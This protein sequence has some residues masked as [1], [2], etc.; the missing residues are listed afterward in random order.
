LG[1]LRVCG[2]GLLCRGRLSRLGVEHGKLRKS[3][4]GGDHSHQHQR[5]RCDVDFAERH[6]LDTSSY[7][8]LYVC[9]YHLGAKLTRKRLESG[10]TGRLNQRSGDVSASALR[11]QR[12]ASQDQRQRQSAPGQA[13]PE[14]LTTLFQAA[15]HCWQGQAEGAR[16]LVTS[17]AFQTAENERN[18]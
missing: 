14:Q 5:G 10:A 7:E 13:T 9:G 15:F 18:A 17:L 16:S 6:G 2:S 12:E 8:I 11:K 1:A 3:H 4:G